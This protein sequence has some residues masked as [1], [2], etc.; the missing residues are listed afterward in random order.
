MNGD[1]IVFCTNLVAKEKMLKAARRSFAVQLS[2]V[3]YCA[4][5]LKSNFEIRIYGELSV[6]N[7]LTV[8]TIFLSRSPKLAI[9]DL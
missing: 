5:L 4:L 6:G 8:L 2:T 9:S 7:F 1:L 3:A